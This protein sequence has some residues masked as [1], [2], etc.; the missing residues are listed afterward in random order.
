MNNTKLQ[1]VN[2]LEYDRLISQQVHEINMELNKNKKNIFTK[3]FFL[4]QNYNTPVTNLIADPIKKSLIYI[5][6]IILI[7][8]VFKYFNILK[9]FLKIHT[10]KYY[11][12]I[13][14]IIGIFISVNQYNLNNN[15]E[16]IV[17]SRNK[18][19]TIYEFNPHHTIPESNILKIFGSILISTM[20]SQFLTFNLNGFEYINSGIAIGI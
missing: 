9:Y 7:A 14:L 19:P 20:I 18:I 6:L 5:I 17:K 8:I 3:T 2:P 16:Y 15:I 10:L 13:L 12:F 11:G 1:P 4:F